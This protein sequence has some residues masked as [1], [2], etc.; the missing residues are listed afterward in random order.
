MEVTFSTITQHVF[1]TI[2][3]VRQMYWT[4]FAYYINSRIGIH[5]YTPI[6]AL[7]MECIVYDILGNSRPA[8][9]NVPVPDHPAV[10]P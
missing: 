3:Y 1:M 4:Y 9:Q 8:E 10:G 5:R 2:Q 6:R 7:H